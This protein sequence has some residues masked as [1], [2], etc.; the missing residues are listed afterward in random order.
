MDAQPITIIEAWNS[1]AELNNLLTRAGLSA[2]C[3][4]RLM[5]DESYT[6]ASDLSVTVLKDLQF[7]GR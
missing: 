5:D 4:Y 2:R 1:Y 6:S 3:T 7:S